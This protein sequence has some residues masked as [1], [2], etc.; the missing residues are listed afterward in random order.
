MVERSI[1]TS[2]PFGVYLYHDNS[3]INVTSSF[4]GVQ[5]GE[6]ASAYGEGYFLFMTPSKD[7]LYNISVKKVIPISGVT[8]AEFPLYNNIAT[9]N[10]TSF[11]FN[12]GDNIV[13]LNPSNMKLSNL[14]QFQ[15]DSLNFISSFGTYYDFGLYNWNYG[16]T[17]VYEGNGSTIDKVYNFNGFITDSA[18][19]DN[20]LAFTGQPPGQP[21]LLYL[22]STLKLTS[23][24]TIIA[25]QKGTQL[26]IN[27]VS[28]NMPS[29]GTLQLNNVAIGKY[30]I[31][32]YNTNYDYFYHQYKLNDSNLVIN[33]ILNTN[34][35]GI[36]P[37]YPWE[38]LGPNRP[39][40]NL[41]NNTVERAAGHFGKI[42]LDYKNP[43][44]IYA[45][46]GPGMTA[47]FGPFG[48][49]GIYKTT[50]GGQTWVQVDYGLPLGSVSSI[51][52]NQSNPNELLA[53]ISQ[54]GVYRTSDGGNY[55][56]KVSRY[57][58]VTDFSRDG[59]ILYSNSGNGFPGTSGYV[60]ETSNF[61][62]TFTQI[63]HFPIA[64]VYV[65]ASQSHIYAL[66]SNNT[67]FTSSDNGINWK[68]SWNFQSTP[69][70]GPSSVS[71]SP[72]NPN[73]VFVTFGS[74]NGINYGFVSYN[75]GST[76]TRYTNLTQVSKVRF[77]KYQPN[78]LWIA[79]GATIYYSNN[80]GATFSQHPN[81]WDLHNMAID[82]LIGGLAFD[83]AD[84]GIYETKDYGNSWFSINGNLENF[85]SY[86]ISASSNGKLIL[87]SMQDYSTLATH[88]GSASWSYGSL[89]DSVYPTEGSV[90]YVNQANSSIVYTYF[91]NLGKLAFS[92]DSALNF[93]FVLNLSNG[94][95]GTQQV[96]AQMPCDLGKVFFA[97]FDGIYNSSNWGKTWSIWS[98]SP[99]QLLSMSVSPHGSIFASNYS[100][101]Y[102]YSDGKWT[103]ASGIPGGA[104]SIS[105]DPGNP[106]IVVVSESLHQFGTSYLS[107]DGGTHFTVLPTKI[108]PWNGGMW[109]SEG[110]SSM[111]LYFLNTTGYPLIAL[112]NH[113]AYLSENF[114]TSWYNIS[115]NL[116]SGEL[117]DLAFEND[118]LFV[119]TYGEGIVAIKNFSTSTLPGTLRG[120]VAHTV[121]SLEVNGS[122]VSL[123]HGYYTKYL[124][125]GTYNVTLRNLVNN[126]VF[127]VYKSVKIRS[128]SN[129]YY[130][131]TGALS[132][133]T[134]SVTFTE[135]GLSSDSE[136]YVNITGMPSSGPIT[137]SSYY[138]NLANGTYSYTIATSDKTYS[139]SPSSGSFTV[140]AASVSE[141]ITFS[142]VTY[143]VTFTETGLPS[144]TTWY[145]NLS[146][147]QSYSGVRNTISFSEPNGTYSYS[148]ASSN[149][150]W[151]SSGSSFTV[152]GHPNS[153]TIT[154]SLVKYT[155]TFTETGLHREPHGMSISVMGSPQEQ[156]QEHPIPSR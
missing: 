104:S 147:G 121:T 18:F 49:G 91:P 34:E 54:F 63:D 113:G 152:N 11:I 142:R 108:D 59:S 35:N 31:L 107:T 112:T 37:T 131:Y 2:H 138:V 15:P 32:A 141:S 95:Y 21:V 62:S 8:S 84:Q 106:S 132:L 97:S 135:A 88:N 151:S 66:L 115:Y 109:Y 129:V 17:T 89:S 28:Y 92:N 5:N 155:V 10:G 149:K 79:G 140:N 96:F 33:I 154:F 117:T 22:A 153:Q 76:F 14:Y 58:N 145:V 85:L 16:N 111:L 101:V 67:L 105:I 143:T 24:I 123:H 20:T 156:S 26:M 83:I 47:E 53:A 100:G 13:A 12:S 134:Y 130:N 120:H 64:V 46:T 57:T 82:P 44:L 137:G 103:T 125:P 114:G 126:S 19:T 86:G 39:L 90:N 41:N 146:N 80:S 94:F 77:N 29:N 40:V 3:L 99:K 4:P 72:N 81:I 116:I 48:D 55:W 118:T 45:S 61:G 25:K 78:E 128:F 102:V 51:Y 60:I 7:F 144:G 139:P 42:A 73:E 71:A 122:Q 70:M 69:G 52:I 75:G 68:P 30:S 56:Y 133:A 119:S 36:I 87:S 110:G 98:G 9:W 136:W 50:N 38:Q 127:L 93:H 27:G 65:S 6:F 43:N 23:N 74:S 150:L 1:N 148:I 124:S